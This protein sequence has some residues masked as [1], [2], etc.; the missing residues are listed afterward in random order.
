MSIESFRHKGLR[1]ILE[2]DDARG[3]PAVQA[4]KI[5]RI[6]FALQEAAE[7]SDMGHYPGWR[8]HPLKGDL[9]GRWS[10][11]VTGNW[12][13]VFR[14]ENGKAFDVDFIDYH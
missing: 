8:L 2:A 13:I 3:V 6:L 1:R 14:F 4:P 10:V 12:R 9:H 7:V 11:T 5:R